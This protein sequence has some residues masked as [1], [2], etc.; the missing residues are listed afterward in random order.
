MDGEVRSRR[1]HCIVV[2]GEW[3]NM[4]EKVGQWKENVQLVI[5]SCDKYMN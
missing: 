1:T 5:E 4:L 2:D 3:K